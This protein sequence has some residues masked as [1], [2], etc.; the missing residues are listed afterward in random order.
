MF[1]GDQKKKK[2]VI[3]KNRDEQPDEELYV[4]SGM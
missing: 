1:W 4:R 3:F 2:D